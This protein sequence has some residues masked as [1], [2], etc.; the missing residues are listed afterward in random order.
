MVVLHKL[1]ANVCICA[2]NLKVKH[3]FLNTKIGIAE[4]ILAAIRARF[5]GFSGILAQKGAGQGH[6]EGWRVADLVL[7]TVAQRCC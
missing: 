1:T 5:Y 3:I 2:F 7:R 4:R 6:G